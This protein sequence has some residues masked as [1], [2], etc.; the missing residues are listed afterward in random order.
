V[1]HSYLFE[2]AGLLLNRV[3]RFSALK[4]WGG[5]AHR[6]QEGHRRR[7]TQ[8]RH[9]LLDNGAKFA[10]GFV[11]TIARDELRRRTRGPAL[12]PST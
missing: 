2:A 8:A 5:E 1:I 9:G 11:H 4:A 10:I 7:G 6:P 3:T 12:K